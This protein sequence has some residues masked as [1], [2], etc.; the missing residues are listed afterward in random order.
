MESKH[1]FYM[2]IIVLICVLIAGIAISIDNEKINK[3]IQ[4]CIK[5]GKNPVECKCAFRPTPFCG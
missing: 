4:E 3:Q 5:L 1:Y 2:T